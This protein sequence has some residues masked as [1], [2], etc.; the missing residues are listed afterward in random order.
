MLKLSARQK[1]SADNDG[2]NVDAAHLSA[3]CRTFSY[4]SLDLLGGFMID[5][6]WNASLI[7]TLIGSGLTLV[8][9]YW[10]HWY[11]KREAAHRDAEN[12]LGLLQAF[13]DEI[14]TLWGGCK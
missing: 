1:D 3:G 10:T 13:H 11:Q 6:E 5:F 12:V 9:V 8:G 14:E 7:S 4:N 2:V